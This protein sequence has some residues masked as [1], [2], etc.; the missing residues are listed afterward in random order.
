[1][2]SLPTTSITR[3]GLL[4]AGVGVGAV[5]L[6]AGCA[7][8]TG[9][10]AE[11]VGIPASE[12]VVPDFIPY[13][14][15]PPDREAGP[16]GIP[17]VYYNYPEPVVR[18]GYPLPAGETF[19]ALMQGLPPTVTPK[20]NQ[21][22]ALAYEQV[23]T[24][25]DIIY[26]TYT[27]YKDKFQVTMAS[28]DLP[29]MCM[30]IKVAQLPRLLDKHFADLTDILGGDGVAQYPGLAN[31]PTE[32]WRLATLNGRIWGIAKPSPPAAYTL[33][34]RG[35]ILAERGISDPSP[36]LRDGADFVDLLKELTNRDKNEFAMGADPLGWL[37]AIVKQMIGTP[38]NWAQ[39]DGRFVHELETEQYKDVLAET[40]KIIQAGYLHPNSFSDP[41][42]NRV[43]YSSGVTGLYIQ[44]FSGWGLDARNEPDWNVGN[45]E[46]P[47]WEG[48]G[49][50]PARKTP[51][52]YSAFV[53]F[54]KAD[55]ARL[56]QLLQIADWVASPFG[57]Q[58]FL[59]ASYGVEGYSYRMKD[60]NPVTIPDSP[61]VLAM[62]YAGGNANAVLFTPGEKESV[63]AQREHLERTLPDGRDDAS[64]G[65]Y[66]ETAVSKAP[67]M[68]SALNDL[69]REILQ[70]T[71]PMSE[72]DDMVKRW[73]DQV[74]AKMAAEFEEAADAAG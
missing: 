29:D 28:G 5:G 10:G 25:F 69:Q 19:T 15:A 50:A 2:S 17:P 21:N 4:T 24:P 66:S 72:W 62:S 1:M 26:G 34:S 51:P 20:Q 6:L 65:L 42:Q 33:N 67:T 32:T 7:G 31:I 36:Q 43:W 55:D 46:L 47:R 41:G 30:I 52:G 23:G 63:D 73:K 18:D 12:A 44:S 45:I 48:G 61:E 22:Y 37:M 68:S 8:E 57:T 54:K 39:E 40:A 59:D 14:G 9:A 60:G 64:L 49:P 35:D 56:H 13:D 58:Q 70:G 3:R 11:G 53:A 74:G 71:K 27:D 16:G 38:N